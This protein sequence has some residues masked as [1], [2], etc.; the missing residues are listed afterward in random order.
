M[1]TLP[2][3]ITAAALA[4]SVP[5]ASAQAIWTAGHGGHKM[6]YDG[7]EFTPLWSAAP[8][9]VVDG[10]ARTTP[11]EYALGTLL[12]VMPLEKSTARPAG[13]SWDFLGVN[14][15]EDVWI[16]PQIQ[17]PD[18]PWIG[19]STTA[20]TAGD[21]ASSNSISLTAVTGNGVDA[22]GY[23][24]IY[25]Q[26]A[27][28]QPVVLAQT[29]GGISGSGISLVAGSGHLHVNF[30]FTEP[31]IYNA[32]YTISGTHLVNGFETTTATYSYQVVPEPATGALL[33][34]AGLMVGLRARRNQ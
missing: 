14:A 21:W 27:F 5:T 33:A 16:F 1:N 9:C 7:S 29:F 12:P 18:L 2:M 30:A 28:G 13:S 15:A 3:I 26:D 34:L 24:S 6:K 8:G 31:G 17:E 20:L 23:M 22:G 32:T 25:E 10:V 19:F 11:G 4:L